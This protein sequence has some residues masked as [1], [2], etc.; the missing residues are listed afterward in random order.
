VLG[1]E[2]HPAAEAE[3]QA[4]IDYYKE[5]DLALGVKFVSQVEAAIRR[6]RGFPETYGLV[7]HRLRHVVTRRFPYAVI[8]EVMENR[9]FIWAVAHGGRKPG[10]W[11]RRL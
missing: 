7:A 2:Y 8:Y 11:K 10:Y 3:Y 6:A 4:A 1:Y 5:I 9:I